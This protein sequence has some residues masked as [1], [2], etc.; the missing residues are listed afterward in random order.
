MIN[1]NLISGRERAR[2]VGENAG[3]IAFFIAVIAF[4]MAMGIFTLQQ[5]KLGR[6]KAQLR[7]AHAE[8]EKYSRQKAQIDAI[9]RQVD[10]KRPLVDL[11]TTA[12]DSER[13]WCMGL[14]DIGKALPD[15]VKLQSIR[16][17]MLRPQMVDV[18]DANL[19]I[20]EREGFTITGS[21]SKP[22]SVASLMT[23]LNES[24]SFSGT[25]YGRSTQH[26]QTESNV[27]IYDFEVKVFL[28]DGR[29]EAR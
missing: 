10:N 6:L 2:R 26:L 24:K 25:E 20:A 21:A 18:N 5:T 19:R 9:K 29:G 17:G 4:V 11:L 14:A 12:R 23:N 3:R 28:D 7:Q 27:P 15:D 16:S 13:K 22:P 1:V 8:I